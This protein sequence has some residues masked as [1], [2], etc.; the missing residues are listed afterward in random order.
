MNS[1]IIENESARL[2]KQNKNYIF[3]MCKKC[4][5]YKG[6]CTKNRII[7]ICAKKG[8]KNKE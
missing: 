1:E 6:K 7:R 2:D 3:G 8:L 4:R 5:F